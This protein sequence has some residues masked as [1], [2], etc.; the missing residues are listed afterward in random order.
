MFAADYPYNGGT[1]RFTNLTKK[2]QEGFTL[3]ELMI[4]VAIV[5]VLAV[6]AVYGVRK[7]LANAKTAEARNSLGQ[8][9][10]DAAGAVERE[11]GTNPMLAPGGTSTLMRSF[12]ATASLVPATITAI[13][14][15]KYQSN[16][17]EWN[18][19]DAVTGW[20]CLK[21]S[22]EEPQYYA[23][24]YISA[25]PDANSGGFT[26]QAYGDLNGD[27]TYSTFTV[28]GSAY[29]GAIAISPNVQETN[30]EE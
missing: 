21:F 13:G 1:M 9:A 26:A 16:K 14:G 17:T 11:K 12:C 10:K 28:Q 5:G 7:Y 20:Q 15:Q 30:P 6:L 25:V 4:V 23:Y 19:G 3:I 29:S 22:L 27:Q 2:S 8:L 24:T 18:T